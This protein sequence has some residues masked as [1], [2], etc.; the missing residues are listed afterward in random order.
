MSIILKRDHDLYVVCVGG[1][2]FSKVEIDEFS[3]LGVLQKVLRFDLCDEE[4][5][6][7]YN[8]AQLFVFP[9]LY[10]G[11]GIPIL[12]AFE[13]RCPIACSNTSSLPE[14]AGDAAAYF[15]PYDVGSIHSTIEKLLY[16]K[17]LALAFIE[18][19]E[20]RL[21]QFSFEKT[22]KETLRIYKELL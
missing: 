2:V 16:N 3:N 13:C 5:A 8:N 7:S 12:E 20:N 19:G 17:E 22:A 21:K 18:K 9:S 1:G 14:V 10:E 6:C 15:D 4:L 11:F